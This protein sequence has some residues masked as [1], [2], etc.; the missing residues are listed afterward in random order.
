M[1]VTTANTEKIDEF[2]HDRAKHATVAAVVIGRNEGDRL[3]RCLKSL[4]H[5]AMPVIYVDSGSTDGSIENAVQLG[6]EVVR[7]DSNIPFTAARARNAGLQ[8]LRDAG[9][10]GPV[11]FVDGDCEIEAG[12]IEAARDRLAADPRLGIV[13]G[14]RR[15]RFPDRSVFNRLCD[16]EWD[17]PIGPAL[18]VGGDMMAQT[19]ALAAIGGFRDEMIAGE[20]PEMCLRLRE[21][22]GSIERL[23]LPMTVHDADM[24]RFGQWWRRA[25][26]A[27]HA[28]AEGNWLH[29]D[30]PEAF[31]R[32]EVR[33]AV[34]WAMLLP[35]AIL[36][37]MLVLGPWALLGLLLYPLQ[38]ARLA[39]RMGGDREAL[40]R[41]GFLT[42]SKFPEAQGIAEFHLRR[43][44]GRRAGLIE[45]K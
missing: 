7:L 3:V 25:R 21:A 16:A 28:F 34:L 4:Q 2:P 20:E 6:A 22:G 36:L 39:M 33:R 31:W 26:R 35:A 9:W 13:A 45:Y 30:R 23:D 44:W 19:G 40:I 24:H 1:N 29:G 32:R 8:R 27:G 11:Q 14:R 12:W 5:R 37:A 10:H 17:T 18:A 41:A 15:E 43:L 42:L 38:I